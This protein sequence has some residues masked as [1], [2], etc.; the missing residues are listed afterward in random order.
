MIANLEQLSSAI[1]AN[2]PT[3]KSVAR[4]VFKD[5]ECGAWVELIEPR[6]AK[7]LKQR[8]VAY[9]RRS[10]A[11]VT[12][13]GIRPPHGKTIHP[14]PSYDGKV[15]ERVLE[16]L[17]V[18]DGRVHMTLHSVELHDRRH[19][20]AVLWNF[21]KTAEPLQRVTNWSGDTLQ[22]VTNWIWQENSGGTWSK[23]VEF[24]VEVPS[25]RMNHGGVRIG[26][27]VEGVEQCA[28]PV[29]LMF[30]FTE[31]DWD[32]AI[33]SVEDEVHEIWMETHGCEDC[34]T[35]DIGWGKPVDPDC[36]TCRGHGCAI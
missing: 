32:N 33:R 18:E 8:W 2:W 35:D 28:E 12:V 27:I 10:L 7:I 21:I 26:S 3:I 29:E 19:E 4:R 15:P 1:G 30:P 6:P 31:D 23:R 13:V 25:L 11:G 17:G 24:Q 20:A 22:R 5:T 9:I 14:D 16:Y 34:A 36:K